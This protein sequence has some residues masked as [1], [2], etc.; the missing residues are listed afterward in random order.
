MDILNLINRLETV[1]NWHSQA[2]RTLEG[3]QAT[4]A[5]HSQAADDINAIVQ[6]VLALIEVAS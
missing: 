5:F 6:E 3:Q 4:A 1:A 2:W